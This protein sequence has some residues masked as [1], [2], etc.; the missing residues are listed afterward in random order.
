MS[1]EFFPPPL[2]KDREPENVERPGQE[3]SRVFSADEISGV[4]EA[5]GQSDEPVQTSTT[6]DIEPR[7]SRITDID[8]DTLRFFE[9]LFA[10]IEQDRKAAEERKSRQLAAFHRELELESGPLTDKDI[11]AIRARTAAIVDG[12]SLNIYLKNTDESQGENSASLQLD[13]APAKTATNKPSSTSVRPQIVNT[14]EPSQVISGQ[15]RS[16]GKD[17][18]SKKVITVKRG[19]GVKAFLN[20]EIITSNRKNTK[21]ERNAITINDLLSNSKKSPKH[22]RQL[23]GALALMTIFGAST[24]IASQYQDGSKKTAQNSAST[25]PNSI[26]PV[27]IVKVPTVNDWQPNDPQPTAIEEANESTAMAKNKA[28]KSDQLKATSQPNDALTTEDMDLFDFSAPLQIQFTPDPEDPDLYLSRL[29]PESPTCADGQK[30][31][32]LKKILDLDENY[33]I[34]QCADGT[35]YLVCE[36]EIEA[37][38][39]DEKEKFIVEARLQKEGINHCM[40]EE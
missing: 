28:D 1:K 16:V 9:D 35:R 32:A 4:L 19:R 36:Q 12:H 13:K 24:Y 30:P 8:E 11:A 39:A 34:L 31:Q 21:T 2:P 29:A 20:Q 23:V 22:L 38:M 26:T 33:Q 25:G 10:K 7:R 40:T 14:R 6:Q 18:K 37:A 17:G 15:V 27:N 5:L 3:S